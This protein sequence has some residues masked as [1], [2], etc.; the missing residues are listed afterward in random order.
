MRPRIIPVLLLDD[1][2]LYKT[3]R[4]NKPKYIGDPINA[5]KLFNEMEVDELILLDIGASKNKSGIDFEMIQQMAEE[6]FFPMGYGGGVHS[7][8]QGKKLYASG[9]E[10]V[11]INSAS[12][13]NFDLISQ[14]ADH[15]GSQSVVA[16]IDV[17]KSMWGKPSIY[18]HRNRKLIKRDLFDY[19]LGLESAGA[20]EIFINDVENDGV[21]QGYNCDLFQQLSKSVSIPLVA[22]GGAGC[23]QDMKKVIDDGAH[24]AA[25]GSLFVYYGLQN[26]VL[27]NYP[28][29]EQL[30]EVLI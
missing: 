3:V 22:C 21:M 5:I 10:K 26:G 4:F 20:G 27:I 29:Q 11:S 28:K 16:S 18:D 19:V 1:K 8:E 24:A 23:L 15:A 12:F 7:L 2:G 30:N 14:L 13:K 9:F 25:A 6:S 17:K